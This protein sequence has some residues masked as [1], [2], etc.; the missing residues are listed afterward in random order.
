MKKTESL[1]RLLV[2]REGSGHRGESIP[3]SL[4]PVNQNLSSFWK[5]PLNRA[6]SYF[7]SR[8]R[9]LLEAATGLQEAKSQKILWEPGSDHA[10]FLCSEGTTGLRKHS[11]CTHSTSREGSGVG[12]GLDKAP[13]AGIFIDTVVPKGNKVSTDPGPV[14]S[15]Q[16]H[17]LI[18]AR[19]TVFTRA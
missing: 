11:A 10:H 5:L 8:I 1:Q 17:R 14:V 6:D 9:Y 13:T 3:K 16:V 4:Y 12:G 7:L 19:F 2:R 18:W 15:V